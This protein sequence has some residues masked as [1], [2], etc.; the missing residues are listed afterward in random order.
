MMAACGITRRLPSPSLFSAAAVVS[1]ST[2][3]CRVDPIASCLLAPLLPFVSRLLA[4]CRIACCHVPPPR[5]T[6]CRTA[7]ARVH[8]RPL[9]FVC[10]SWLS[11]RISSHHLC[12][13]TRRHLTTGC[14]VT[15]AD[16]QAS[17]PLP[18]LRLSP[19]SHPVKLASSPLSSLSSTS[20]AVIVVVISRRA[21][22]MVIVVIDVAR[23]A[24]AIII[25]FAVRRAVAIVVI[26]SSTSPSPVAPSP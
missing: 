15:V 1:R 5:V 22:A 18:R 7:V 23:C 17:S 9:L 24:V 4:G 10:S 2:A 16:A 14:V 3:G 26:A 8:P 20:V 12:L 13:S 19:S 25:D 11:R 6:F 21:V